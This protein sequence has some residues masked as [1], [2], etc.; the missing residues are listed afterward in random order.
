MN[1]NRSSLRPASHRKGDCPPPGGIERTSGGSSKGDCPL[2]RAKRRRGRVSTAL[3]C[4]L[5]LAGG[6]VLGSGFSLLDS[7]EARAVSRAEA[8]R[9][10]DELS[11]DGGPLLDGS[12]RLARIVSLTAP[13]VVHI[14]SEHRGVG[15]GRV[16]ETGSGIVMASPK[17]AG[18][19]VVTNRH[20][21]S[22]ADLKEISIHLYD[23]RVIEPL[24]VWTDAASD[25]AILKIDVPNVQP[26]R[27][28]DSDQVEIGS[29][30]LAMGSPFGL[31]QSVTF[32]IVS[33]KGRRSLKLGGG[34]SVL[35]QDF[36]QTDAAIN[37]GNSGGP[38]IDLHGRVVAINTAIASNSGG[39]AGIGFS[40]PSNLVRQ[41]MDQLL[42][43]GQV[44]RAY[45]GVRLD[46]AF[47]LDDARRLKLPRLR[48]AL[49]AEVYSDT[50]A[51]RAGLQVG[52]VVLK[53][54]D[55]E[56]L[57]HDHLINLVSLTPV[58]MRVTLVVVRNGREQTLRV[59]LGDRH[60]LERSAAPEPDLPG[61]P[62]EPA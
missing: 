44:Q 48:G 39:N 52:D 59:S 7:L 34:R 9:L 57:D 11:T 14:Q 15:G 61:I 60:D 46:D 37:P 3:L 27:W 10:Y 25:I 40:I 26:A 55:A 35:N 20:V 24:R 54:R 31:S 49:V 12:R 32:G 23:G 18:S 42:E 58:G 17:L 13:S 56:I 16:Q 28:G 36:L 51:S 8:E 1:T 5:T 43:H 50:P 62:P 41:V 4:C 21:I 6:F 19:Y 30:V 38:L 2:F 53:F 22:G 45:L 29:M 33:A 47:D